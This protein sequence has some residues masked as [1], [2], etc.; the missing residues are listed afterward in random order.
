MLG[1]AFQE[2]VDDYMS[3]K[4]LKSVIK[5]EIGGLFSQQVSFLSAPQGYPVPT[6]EQ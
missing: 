4:G 1:T 3:R 6:E 2:L 5:N